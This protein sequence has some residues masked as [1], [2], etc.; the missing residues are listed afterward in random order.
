MRR[1]IALGDVR[2]FRPEHCRLL[3]LPPSAFTGSAAAAESIT[4]GKSV[5]IPS[6]SKFTP[7]SGSRRREV[8]PKN[9]CK[10]RSHEFSGRP[11]FA[12]VH[13][14]AGGHHE[15]IF[16]TSLFLTVARKFAPASPAAREDVGDQPRKARRYV[17]CASVPSVSIPIC[18]SAMHRLENR[19]AHRSRRRNN[20][21]LI[22]LTCLLLGACASVNSGLPTTAGVNGDT[23]YVKEHT[24]LRLLTTSADVYYCPKR[25]A[26]WEM[27]EGHLGRSQVETAI[28]AHLRRCFGRCVTQ[29]SSATPRSSHPSRLA[30]GPVLPFLAALRFSGAAGENKGEAENPWRCCFPLTPLHP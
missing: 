20:M 28:P 11:A 1:R 16:K 25:F 14:Q 10:K 23:W 22:A 13:C 12:S 26:A 24:L 18:G 9:L 3:S 21:K 5:R 7:G 2:R 17:E 8:H 29:R 19:C 15:T 4:R 27:P 6:L 30:S